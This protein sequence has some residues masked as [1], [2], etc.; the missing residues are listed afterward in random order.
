MSGELTVTISPYCPSCGWEFAKN[1]NGH[2]TTP[3][4]FCSSCGVDLSIV[5]FNN[6]V[7][8]ASGD[9]PSGLLAPN[10]T[11]VSTIADTSATFTFTVAP[12][13]DSAEFQ[14]RVDGGAWEAAAAAVSPEVIAGSEDEVI[15]FRVRS[16]VTG[17]PA[18][19]GAWSP[20]ATIVVG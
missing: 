9:T 13:A 12:D 17:P 7:V 6:N 4:D 3:T 10:V 18:I 1:Y 8:P 11:A 15:D 5:Q 19:D 14:S 20:I 2:V 16:V